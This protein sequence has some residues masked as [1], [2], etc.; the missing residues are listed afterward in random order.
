MPGNIKEGLTQKIIKNAALIAAGRIIGTLIIA[1]TKILLINYLGP[2][3]AGDL[4][5]VL[6]YISIFSLLV[7][8]G[9]DEIVIREISKNI[10]VGKKFISNAIIIKFIF[11][12]VNLLIAISIASHSYFNFSNQRL[13]SIYIYSFSLLIFAFGPYSASFYAAMKQGFFVIFSLIKQTIEL[14]FTLL[15]IK[16]GWDLTTYF[17]LRLVAALIV[18]P[19]IVR[20]A[21]KLHKTTFQLDKSI[22]T[23]LLK[24]SFPIALSSA[25]I[26]VFM[27]IDQ[28]MIDAMVNKRALGLYSAA[29]HYCELFN[30]IPSA[31]IISSIPIITKLYYSNYEEFRLLYRRILRFLNLIAF[32]VIIISFINSDYIVNLLFGKDFAAASSSVKILSCSLISSFMGIIYYQVLIAAN[33]QKRSLVL[34]TTAAA[35]NVIL[36]LIFIPIMKEKGAALA[37][38]LS[39]FLIFPLGMLLKSTQSLTKD[40][41][42]E[43]WK[44]LLIAIAVLGFFYYFRMNLIFNIIFVPFIYLS[45]TVALKIINFEELK[46][47]IS[48]IMSIFTG[49]E[50]LIKP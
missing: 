9:I 44:Q 13:W 8:F 4:S 25:V 50:T 22:I 33:L 32:P 20:S 5:F 43:I 40:I 16:F 10:D 15:L 24:H 11:A 17:I 41:F 3:S 37:T 1:L 45:A 48:L 12:I 18:Q 19:L 28:L 39:Y 31:L 23:S 30:F 34:T 38:A 46:K 29:V 2:E 7:N 14:I 21:S 47:L 6:V 35:A 42:R 36:N 26:F 49:R 27:R